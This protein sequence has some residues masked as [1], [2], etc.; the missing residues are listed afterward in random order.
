MNQGCCDDPPKV[1]RTPVAR[2][3]SPPQ[4]E[5]SPAMWRSIS[6]LVLLAA[7]LIASPSAAGHA[8]PHPG[9]TQSLFVIERSKNR[10][11]VRYDLR[12]GRSGFYDVRRP[13]DVYWLMLAEDGRR[14]E[15]SGL[16]WQAFGFE[17][18]PNA[19]PTEL[20]VRLIAVKN[21]P[22]SVRRRDGMYRA[23]LPIHG[24]PAYLESL[25]VMTREGGV[26]PT[27]LYLELRGRAVAGGERCWN[28]SVARQNGD[29]GEPSPRAKTRYARLHQDE[30]PAR[31]YHNSKLREPLCSTSF[32]RWR[33]WK[34]L[35]TRAQPSPRLEG[36]GRHQSRL[37]VDGLSALR[38]RL[39][40]ARGV[41]G[42]PKTGWVKDFP[43]RNCRQSDEVLLHGGHRGCA[44]LR[45]GPRG[46]RAGERQL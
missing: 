23:E 5:H 38:Q 30:G 46:A 2:D 22:L 7:G 1:V 42:I 37:R 15:L 19:T 20:G 16:E 26:V 8:T 11:V 41:G 13:L 35:W 12:L 40:F 9:Q 21:R 6:R 31:A 14:L 4:T 45:D 32:A 3:C 29:M 10:N 44:D 28:E 17:L 34:A 39:R 27:V 24:E 36:R 25:F 18:L 43:I 33:S